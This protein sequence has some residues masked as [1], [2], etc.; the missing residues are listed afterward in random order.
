VFGSQALLPPVAADELRKAVEKIGIPCFLGNAVFTQLHVQLAFTHILFSTRYRKKNLY[1]NI[2]VVKL[3][4]YL[5]RKMDR[6]LA[7]N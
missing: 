1:K 4:R 2:F 7:L 6:K 5:V 3:A